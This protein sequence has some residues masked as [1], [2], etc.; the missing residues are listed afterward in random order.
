MDYAFDN[1]FEN[2]PEDNNANP[3]SIVNANHVN[4]NVEYELRADFVYDERRIF[5]KLY[6]FLKS[7]GLV[8]YT[9]TF[10]TCDK[11]IFFVVM[12]T[13]TFLSILN[14]AR[15]EYNHYRRYG[16]TFSSIGEYE[17][18]KQ[19]QLPKTRIIFAGTELGIKIWY[20]INIFPPQFDFESSC[21]LGKSI[22]NMHIAGLFMIYVVVGVFSLYLSCTAC[23]YDVNHYHPHT[24]SVRPR[25]PVSLP[26]P[27]MNDVVLNINRECCICMDTDNIQP[28]VGLPCSHM[29][30]ATCVSRWITTHHTCPVCR[31][32]MRAM[33]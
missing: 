29:F 15:Y 33:V 19:Q 28:W 24:Y 20:I 26:L 5:S 4:N 31:F 16:T 14:S 27:A 25:E 13:V 12:N 30:H 11:P 9:L 17:I 10:T 23:C 2:N 6:V 1:Y 7:I 3:N 21:N 18:W 22:L 8:F 32:D